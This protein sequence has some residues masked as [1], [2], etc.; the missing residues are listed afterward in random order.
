MHAK[1]PDPRKE[2]WHERLMHSGYFLGAVLF[3]LILF[4]MIATVV[5][6]KAPPPPP[7]DEFHGVAVKV[8]PPPAQPPASGAAANNPQFE[9][10]PVVVPVVTPSSTITTANNSAFSINASKVMDQALSHMSDQMAQGTGLAHG[11]NG[12]GSGSGSSFFG[13]ATQGISV[14]FMGTFY[15]FTRTQD[16]KVNQMNPAIYANIIRAFCKGFQAPVGYPCYKSDVTLYSKFF[17]FPPIADNQAGKAFKTPSSTEAF[18]IAHY[19]GSFTPD[20]GGEYR[21][22]GFGD[23]LLAVRINDRVVLDA[24][25]KG[26]LGNGWG[27]SSASRKHVGD[28]LLPGKDSATPVFLG[29]SFIVQPGAS[30]HVD[31]AVGDEGGIF[32][33]GLFL[34]PK[35]PT[36]AFTDKGIPKLPLFGVGALN[37]DDKD[38]LGKYL[39]PECL[40]SPVNFTIVPEKSYSP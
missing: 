6:F 20:A 10:Q 27:Y 4:L 23:N 34:A 17:F 39:P 26:Y 2:V 31:V 38:L 37:G 29:D 15:D 36:L 9:P 19:H 1:A 5:I 22:V 30:I 35:D 7:T 28:I 13:A 25:D 32:C 21:L 8:P 14:G 16:G 40:T 18:W 11:G 3:H 24:S 33:A 12:S